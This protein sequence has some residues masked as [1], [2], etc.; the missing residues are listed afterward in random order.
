MTLN[1][2]EKF[3]RFDINICAQYNKAAKELATCLLNGQKP[4]LLLTSFQPEIL[5]LTKFTSK[6]QAE[7]CAGG[8]KLLL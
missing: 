3:L 1:I 8:N 7:T 6:T 4:L 5:K 2:R